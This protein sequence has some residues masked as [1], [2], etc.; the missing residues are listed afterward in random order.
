MVGISLL[1]GAA[2]SSAAL[3]TGRGRGRRAVH[4]R[5]EPAQRTSAPARPADLTRRSARAHPLVVGG[6]LHRAH[7]AVGLV[8]GVG[9]LTA[10]PS[11]TSCCDLLSPVAVRHRYEYSCQGTP[12][13]AAD[14]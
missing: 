6:V 1:A 10:S 14:Q 3:T 13:T 9:A 12:R 8:E 2:S 11:R 4:H 5:V 7:G